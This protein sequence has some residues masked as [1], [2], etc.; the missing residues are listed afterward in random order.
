MNTLWNALERRTVSLGKVFGSKGKQHHKHKS[1][2]TQSHTQWFH[3]MQRKND[4]I[5][6]KKLRTGKDTS[7]YTTDLCLPSTAWQWYVVSYYRIC[8]LG[9]K[10]GTE[11]F[12][13]YIYICLAVWLCIKIGSQNMVLIRLLQI[14]AKDLTVRFNRLV[15]YT[16]LDRLIVFFAKCKASLKVQRHSALRREN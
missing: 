1:S 7:Q 11:Y 4:W 6:P 2:E 3:Q 10:N 13:L 9:P 15:I 14:G 5:F 16:I 8:Q 12:L